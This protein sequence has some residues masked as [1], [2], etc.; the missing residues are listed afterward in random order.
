[1]SSLFLSFVSS[2]PV[3]IASIKEKP[4]K[5]KST[6]YPPP[7]PPFTH[8]PFSSFT[9]ACVCMEQHSRAERRSSNPTRTTINPLSPSM[10][11]QN[12]PIVGTSRR[13]NQVV[14]THPSIHLLHSR[15][16]SSQRED[17]PGGRRGRVETPHYTTP[18]APYHIS[19]P[20]VEPRMSP[21]FAS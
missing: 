19:V 4:E 21:D 5:P 7:I 18:W 14:L 16:F 20:Y 13:E 17:R 11:G 2:R 8:V 3:R 10:Y 6:K 15:T 9:C 1:M 12:A